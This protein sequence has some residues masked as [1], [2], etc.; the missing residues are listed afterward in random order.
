MRTMLI[1]VGWPVLAGLVLAV[2]T[3]AIRRDRL[4]ASVPGA[5]RVWAIAG[6]T[7]AVLLA[8]IDQIGGVFTFVWGTPDLTRL[9]ITLDFV[10]PL[11][12]AGVAVAMLVLPLP[13]RRRGGSATLTRRGLATFVDRRWLILPA[14]ALVL[15]LALTVT[16]GALAGPDGMYM[17]DAGIMQFGTG[18]YGWH[19]SIPSLIAIAALLIPMLLTLLWISRPPLQDDETGDVTT[20]RWRSRQILRAASAGLLMH[21]ASV[22]HSFSATASTRASASTSEGPVFVQGAFSALETPL[23]VAGFGVDAAGWWIVFVALVVAVSTR[24]IR[25]ARLE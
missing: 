8:L 21:L 15:V 25:A 7:A 11:V 12:A 23:R 19:R 4:Q 16:G 6:L 18:I 9:L 5:V 10:G 1:M 24:T 22:L 13:Q 2:L 14:L 20:R 17:T 3:V